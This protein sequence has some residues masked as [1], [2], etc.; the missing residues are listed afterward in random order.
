MIPFDQLPL[1]PNIRREDLKSFGTGMLLLCIGI[2][3]LLLF[4]GVA[5]G[6][7][8]AVIPMVIYVLVCGILYFFAFRNVDPLNSSIGS[9]SLLGRIAVAKSDLTPQGLVFLDETLWNAKSTQSVSNGMEVEV[10]AVE[11]LTLQVAPVSKET[12]GHRLDFQ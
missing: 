6:M 5:G 10:R 3:G 9:E 7:L 8:V 11:G 2:G 1:L 12:V 4:L